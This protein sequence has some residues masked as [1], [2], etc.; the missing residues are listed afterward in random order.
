MSAAHDRSAVK[1]AV[2]AVL[3]CCCSLAAALVVAAQPARRARR[4]GA[5]APFQPHAAA[6]SS[7]APTSR[8]PA[9]A[10][11][12]TPRAAARPTPAGA[13]I[14]T[15]F[16]TVFATNLTPDAATGI[17]GWS[18]AH[19]WRAMHNGRSRD[20]RLLYPAF[21]YPNYTQVT[22]EDADAM[23]A[24]LRSLPPV[25]QPNRPHELRFPYD[26]QVALAVWRALF[27][28]PGTLRARPARARP[29]GTAAPTSCA[30]SATATPATAAATCSARPASKLELARRPDPDAELVRAVAGLAAR[31]RRGRLGA[32]AEVVA[33][34]KNGVVAARLGAW[35]RWPRW[36]TAARST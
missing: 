36:C 31:G 33:L 29:N 14:E 12:A 32:R 17:G 8:A 15:P 18:A 3:A 30:A 2:A 28:R 23:F 27:F 6:A 35:D 5:A 13:A 11:P 22:R 19:F 7:A 20:G 16:G 24:Y 26:S 4:L 9:T 34:L 10:S 21:P 25:A 1:V